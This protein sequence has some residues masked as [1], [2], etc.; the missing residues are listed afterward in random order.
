MA[1]PQWSTTA[2]SLATIPEGT[3]YSTT[4]LAD[5]GV[6]TVYYQ[7]IAG[8]LPPGMQVS[9]AGVV[10]GVPK[11]AAEI[12]GDPAKASLDIT[13]KFAIRAYTV[14]TVDT[15][16][17]VDR[18]ND[19]TFTITV[20]G[21]TAPEFI[22]PV[23]N[24]GTFYDGTEAQI[25][26]EYTYPGPTVSVKL[27]SGVLPTGLVLSP[28]GLIS[29]V[30]APLV[31][32]PGT[33][34][35]G[36]DST[37]YDQYPFDFSERSASTNY[38]F[39]LEV[40]DGVNSSVGVFEIY[41]YAHNSMSA[42]T[43]SFTADNTFIT[44]DVTPTRTPILLT[45]AGSLG[46]VRSNN[47]YAF[48]FEAVDFDGDA[49]G[50]EITVGPG[51]GFDADGTGFDEFGFD[52]GTLGLPPGL[53]I[54]EYTGWFY[55]FIPNQGSTETTYQ[56]AIR[57]FKENDPTVISNFYYFNITITGPA[58]TDIAWLTGPDLG[59]INNGSISTLAVEAV[60][61]GG[62]QLQ[63]DL[64]SGS[65]SKLPQGLTLKSSGHITGTVSFNTFALDG[66]TTTF[67]ETVRTQAVTQATTFDSQFNFTVEAF[68]PAP[69]QA[70][71]QI[72]SFIVID[73]GINY[74]TSP[75][76]TIS[77]PPN[78]INAIPAAAGP[79]TLVDGGIDSIAVGNAGLGYIQPPT[80]T[81]T[82]GGGSGA[83][84][85]AQMIPVTL[86]NLVSTRRT[87]T[88]TVVRAFNRPYQGLY[89][90][91]M[92]SI[93]NRALVTQLTQNQ[94]II[95]SD[96]VY[97]SDDSNFG[98]AKAVVYNHAYGLNAASVAKYVSSLNLNHYWKNL[99]LGHVEYAQALDANGNVL[100][101][102][103]YSR[104]ID[105]LVNN[106]GQS[107]SKQV[108]T[109]YPVQTID[110]TITTVY[111]NS[112][113]NMRDQ[114]IDVIGQVSP[115]LPQWMMS[116]QSNGQVLGFTPAWVI[117]YVKPGRGA[118]VVYNIRHQFADRLNLVDFRADRYEL[119]CSMT[120]AWETF[121]DVTPAGQW[122]PQPPAATTFDLAA[123]VP[124][125]YTSGTIFD[126]GSTDFTTPNPTSATTD[127]FD[128]YL[129]FP[130]TNI[131]G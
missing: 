97:R 78:T 31:G 49:I 52:R 92:P 77:A 9:S 128:K 11:S 105:N 88:V 51:I 61:S 80:V 56:F 106:A 18:F 47:Y 64:V 38:Q 117:A 5:A 21:Q 85:I 93:P 94:D 4:V 44:A 63:Y 86:T 26:I 75:T 95:P 12:T 70:G 16:I 118:Q 123:Y 60:N 1:Q 34:E 17:V 14:K 3:F 10:S 82:G 66:G 35:A 45:P 48:K 103:V 57:V 104:V 121:N 2:G 125:T 83:V 84:I 91:A 98:V 124:A 131:L 107:V 43:T 68:A 116:K 28:T 74:T 72:A 111:P 108:P 40:T 112:L 65:N 22:T 89:I 29:G 33:A 102:A 126:G 42:D 71:F 37:Q 100:Y 115:L 46:T 53:E 15:L 6:S 129:M 130:Q 119:D 25:Q 127:A 87:F 101:E 109:A 50:Y 59:I 120:F 110:G 55:G 30:I 122:I 81:V 67:D 76:I 90:K 7:V 20:T 32:P 54:N 24:I 96:F 41:V 73:P 79:V 69:T 8:Q 39:V 62:Y 19:R 113:T 58:G 23:G 99:T 13:S 36:F 27:L 114:V